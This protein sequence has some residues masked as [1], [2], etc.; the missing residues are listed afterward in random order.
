MATALIIILL[1][2]VAP[3]GCMSGLDRTSSALQ[4]CPKYIPQ[5]LHKYLVSDSPLICTGDPSSFFT[6]AGLEYQKPDGPVSFLIDSNKMQQE[7]G[8]SSYL[9]EFFLTTAARTTE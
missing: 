1:L 4:P 2:S 3:K 7:S 8:A 6:N 9:G 5:I